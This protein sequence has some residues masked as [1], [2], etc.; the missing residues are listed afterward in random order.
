M[1]IY[2]I[3]EH[4]SIC[5][6]NI[7]AGEYIQVRIYISLLN[8][9]STHKRTCRM[10][11]EA[12]AKITESPTKQKTRPTCRHIELNPLHV[13]FYISASKSR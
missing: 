12:T 6:C 3:Y 9:I 1:Q 5:L 13:V 2:I 8:K 11:P 4:M 10:Y 7:F